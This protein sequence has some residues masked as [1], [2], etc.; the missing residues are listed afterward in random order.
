MVTWL[1]LLAFLPVFEAFV[2][3]LQASSLTIEIFSDLPRE[4]VQKSHLMQSSK[5]DVWYNSLKVLLKSS[6]GVICSLI[7]I[8]LVLLALLLP[9]LGPG[10]VLSS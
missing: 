9:G 2:L 5:K 1:H 7:C 8:Y 4:S 10:S 3:G 6:K